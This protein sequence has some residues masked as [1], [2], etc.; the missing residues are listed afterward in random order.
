MYKDN[1]TVGIY[2]TCHSWWQWVDNCIVENMIGTSLC[3]KECYFLG[4]ENLY[5]L[6]EKQNLT[7]GKEE[8]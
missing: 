3:E 6:R 5:N 7:F 8:A 2:T 4:K 1:N